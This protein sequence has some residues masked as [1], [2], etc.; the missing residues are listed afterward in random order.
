MGPGARDNGGAMDGERRV[1]VGGPPWRRCLAWALVPLFAAPVFLGWPV[2]RAPACGPGAGLRVLSLNALNDAR[3][4]CLPGRLPVSLLAAA[5]RRSGAD[6]VGLQEVDSCAGLIASMLGWGHLRHGRDTAILSPHPVLGP[7]PGGLGARLSV[8]GREVVVLNVHLRCS[9]YQP[10]QLIGRP[11]R[12]DPP[13]RDAAAAV[14]AALDA[15]GRE[16]D[17]LVREIRW[18]GSRP[19]VVLGDF[20]EPSHLDWT[21]RAAAAG[22]VPVAVAFPASAALAA[23]GLRDAYRQVHPDEV[24]A[25]GHTWG[26]GP[27][28]RIV[29]PDRIDFALFRGPLRATAALVLGE[30]R[31]EAD[32]VFWPYP[33]DH[34][35]VVAE[36]EMEGRGR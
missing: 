34:R 5:I 1:R 32:V 27:P 36:F 7:T 4:P 21:P 3:R 28:S 17:A 33:T 19:L 15:R 18:A 12:G 11:R 2:G 22:L 14:S 35:G 31:R 6:V 24:A 16:V 9:P 10:F 29:R 25:P 30:G 13:L 20:N 26:V 23:E 8:R